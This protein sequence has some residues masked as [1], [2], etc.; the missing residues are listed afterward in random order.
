V[1]RLGNRVGVADVRLFNESTPDLD[2]ATGKCVYNVSVM[3]ASA[4]GAG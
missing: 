3:K 4:K 2:V 1:V